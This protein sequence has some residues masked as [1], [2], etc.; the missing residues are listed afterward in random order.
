MEGVPGVATFCGRTISS[1]AIALPPAATGLLI[2]LTGQFAASFTDSRTP[3]LVERT[4]STLVMQRGVGIALGYE[5]RNGE[6]QPCRDPVPAGKHLTDQSLN[7]TTIFGTPRAAGRNAAEES[8]GSRRTSFGMRR[9]SRVA[10]HRLGAMAEGL[11]APN[12]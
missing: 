2:G 9:Q 3:G 1:D 12:A 6:D 8:L 5:E 7:D 4:V 10:F 11:I